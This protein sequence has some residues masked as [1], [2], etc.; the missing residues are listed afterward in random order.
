MS[1]CYNSAVISAPVDAVWARI[2]DFHDLSWAPEVVTKLDVVGDENGSTPG[3]GRVLNDAFRETL[4]SVDGE[5]KTFSYSIDDGPGPLSKNNVSNYVG[6]VT[7]YPI[8]EDDT[9]FIEWT[10]T[11]TSPDDAAVSDFCNPIYHALLASLKSQF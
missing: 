3:A 8:T 10:S 2:S 11:Y 1:Q 6:T 7:L 9:T 4:V 5:A